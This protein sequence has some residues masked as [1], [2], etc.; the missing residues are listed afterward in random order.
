LV[1]VPL[2]CTTPDDLLAAL[3]AGA[4]IRLES[5][6]T[7]L[8]SYTEIA[9]V[10]LLSETYV[11]TYLDPL[12]PTTTWYRTRYSDSTGVTLTSYSTPWQGDGT[13]QWLCTPTDVRRRMNKSH[14]DHKED[15][16][17]AAC[18]AQVTADICGYTGRRFYPYHDT[19]VYDAGATLERGMLLP[20][21]FGIRAVTNINIRYVTNGA[22]TLVDPIW[23]RLQPCVAELP[24]GWPF[25]QVEMVDISPYRFNWAGYDSAQLEA[26]LGWAGT[27]AD[28][29]EFSINGCVR[30]VRAKSSGQADTVGTGPMGQAIILR[31]FSPSE[32]DRLDW[33]RAPVYR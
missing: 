3:G 13:G 25:V 11:Y 18:C 2:Y 23:Y 10:P 32:R 8:G 30:M 12:A 6:A 14:L 15:D 31:Q 1:L 16:I 29:H 4:L 9:T 20:V 7:Q 27:P 21:D 5:A 26:D 17:I 24:Y 22:Q 19:M 28:I 33:Y